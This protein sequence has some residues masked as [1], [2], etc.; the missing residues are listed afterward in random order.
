M[1]S[2]TR[3]AELLLGLHLD[4]QAVAVPSEAALDPLAA[5]RPVARHGV[6]HEAGEEMAVVDRSVGE[7]RAVVEDEL[8]IGRPLLD[9]AFEG[10]LLLPRLD[11]RALDV[12]EL[13][14]LIDVGIALGRHRARLFGD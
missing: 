7:R 2:A 10:V 5:H 11:D 14:V 9:R 8:V 1:S 4:G 6:L 3:D 12:G 13:G